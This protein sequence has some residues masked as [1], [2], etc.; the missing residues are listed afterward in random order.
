MPIQERHIRNKQQLNLLTEEA[1]FVE[2][3][4]SLCKSS[5]DGQIKYDYIPLMK[6]QLYKP[7]A[8]QKIIEPILLNLSHR[9]FDIV[10]S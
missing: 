8:S 1:D 6:Q 7:W 9:T 5:C 4:A 10:T 2:A 3:C